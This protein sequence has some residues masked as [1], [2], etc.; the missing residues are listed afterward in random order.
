MLKSYEGIV[1]EVDQSKA[2][3]S[4]RLSDIWGCCAKQ[5]A[6]PGNVTFIW[7]IIAFFSRDSC[8][9]ALLAKTHRGKEKTSLQMKIMAKCWQYSGDQTK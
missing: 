2:W 8:S 9:P 1:F 4:Q 5:L 3:L 6:N 7:Q